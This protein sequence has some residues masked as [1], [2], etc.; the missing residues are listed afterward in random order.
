MNTHTIAVLGS[1]TID[2]F[3]QPSETK[4]IT[5]MTE[6]FSE[7][8]FALPHGGKISAE[9]IQEHFGGGAANVGV[10][11]ARLGN[12]VSCL[13]AVGEDSNGKKILEN[14]HAEKISTAFVQKYSD[15]KSGFSLILNA[16]DGE[17]TVI[18][19]SEANQKFEKIAS[20]SDECNAVY[21]CHLS[22]KNPQKI[23]SQLEYFLGQ[24]N[25]RKFFWNPGKERIEEGLEKNKKLLSHC[26]VL[27]LNTEEAEKFSGLS[28]HK[29]ISHREEIQN[30]HTLDTSFQKYKKDNNVPDFVLEVGHIAE[31]FLEMGVKTVVITDGRKGAQV[32]SKRKNELYLFIPCVSSKRVDT[33]GAG[34]S[35]ASAFSHFYLQG[36]TLQKC[37]EYASINAA[38]VVAHQ[39]AQDGLLTH[40]KIQI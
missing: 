13:G 6:E 32:F 36:E 2:L 39:G 27:F 30:K 28:A 1:L 9:H 26:D 3:V 25:S 4:I 11:F 17:R 20:L 12:T 14:L 31:K 19:T 7:S 5:Q 23:F 21:L 18:F 35:F 10:S 16:F 38:S 33:L 29:K 40:K 34:D 15:T 8:F 37:G 24:D 22:G